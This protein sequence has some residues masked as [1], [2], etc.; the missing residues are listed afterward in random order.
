MSRAK[1]VSHQH[2][3]STRSRCPLS[4]TR[5]RRTN[6][7]SISNSPICD[8]WIDKRLIARRL[9]ASAPIASAPTAMAPTAQAPEAPT[10]DACSLTAREETGR[11]PADAESTSRRESASGADVFTM[12]GSL[13]L[14]ASASLQSVVMKVER[15]PPWTRGWSRRPDFRETIGAPAFAAHSVV[16]KEETFRI[17][18]RLDREQSQVVRS[19]KRLLPIRFKKV[20][21]GHIGA[22]V[23]NHLR[24]SSMARCIASTRWRANDASGSWPATPGYAGGSCAPQIANANASSTAGF[25]AASHKACRRLPCRRA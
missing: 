5:I 22:G 6:S 3:R 2:H 13:A 16:H 12:K 20:A 15:F 10:P 19:P 25:M 23:R 1:S 18:A 8:R 24:S 4:S 7:W 11:P 14:S 9:M 21:L 17:V